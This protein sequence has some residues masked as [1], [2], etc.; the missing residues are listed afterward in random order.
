VFRELEV[1]ES[2]RRISLE[3]AARVDE[4]NECGEPAPEPENVEYVRMA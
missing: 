1:Q 2:T 3:E 4:A